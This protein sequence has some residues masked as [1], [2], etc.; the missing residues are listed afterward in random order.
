MNRFV[1]FV[2]GLY[3][4]LCLT[5]WWALRMQALQGVFDAFSNTVMVVTCHLPG[6]EWDPL[7]GRI[8]RYGMASVNL[9]VI[10]ARTKISKDKQ[11]EKSNFIMFARKIRKFWR[12]FF[13]HPKH[14]K[15][16]GSIGASGD[17]VKAIDSLMDTG[18]LLA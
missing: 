18:V 16:R 11:V 2:L 14:S 3:L 13:N 8:I 10:A 6:A 5:R 12:S 7:V 1:P 15:R 17:S 9:L 4:S